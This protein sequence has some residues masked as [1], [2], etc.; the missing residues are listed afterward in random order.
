MVGNCGRRILFVENGSGFGG[1]MV[2]LRRFLSCLDRSRFFPI[3]LM[4]GGTHVSDE[5]LRG[6]GVEVIHQPKPLNR[7]L[8]GV[9]G[10]PVLSYLAYLAELALSLF[11]HLPR[12][13]RVIKKRQIDLVHLN[14]HLRSQLASVV[15]ARLSGVPCIAHLR[16]TRILTR[17]ERMTARL[18]GHFIVLSETSRL[19]YIRQGIPE[20]RISVV[21]DPVPDFGKVN[22]RVPIRHSLGIPLDV[23]AIGILSRLVQGKGH[24]DYLRAAWK[25]QQRF[26]QTRF[27]IVGREEVTNGPVTERLRRLVENFKLKDRVIFAGWR[28][29]IREVISSLDIVVDASVIREGTRLTVLESVA[30]GRPVVATSVGAEQEFFESGEGGIFVA[31]SQPEELAEAVMTLLQ[32]F[33]VAREM[34][35]KG[36]K[37]VLFHCDPKRSAQNLECVYEW[38]LA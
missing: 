38:V 22:G 37:K 19:E 27:L 2:S 21:R 33:K 18:V 11:L 23:P 24:D 35:E 31:P 20:E 1:S 6:L 14:N 12:V 34:A 3:V 9:M 30:M 32:D 16:N 26:P 29:D 10:Y 28:D 4:E 17:T 25:I 7:L 8:Q 36:R 5:L 15:A 13:Y